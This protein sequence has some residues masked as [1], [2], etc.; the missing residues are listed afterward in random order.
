MDA[1]AKSVGAVFI[2]Q[3]GPERARQMREM[4]ANYGKTWLMGKVTSIQAVTVRL[5]G[6]PDNLMHS[7]VADENTTF[8]KR[9][10]PITLG[11]IEVGD[12]VRTEG[13]IRNGVFLATSVAVMAGPR[14]REEGSSSPQF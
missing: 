1:G 8:R 14:H 12:M 2:M 7:F 13:S 5:Q 6:G 11:E 3:I 4:Q 9:H 10:E